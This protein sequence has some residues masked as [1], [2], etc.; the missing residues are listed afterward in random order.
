M[1]ERE[2]LL[3]DGN[4]LRPDRIIMNNGKVT[5]IDYKFGNKIS[6]SY[7][8]QVAGYLNQLWYMGY[9]NQEGYLWYVELGK[10]EK[11]EMQSPTLF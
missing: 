2:I 4:V 6:A 8:K 10:I 1:N 5:V 3:P 9:K 7:K 11:V